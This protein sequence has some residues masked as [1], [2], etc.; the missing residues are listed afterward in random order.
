MPL[1]LEPFTDDHLTQAGELLAQRHARDRLTQPALPPRFEDPAVAR[2]AVEKTWRRPMTS[3]A[4][5]LE[6]GRLIG[7]LLGQAKADTLRERHV[8]V[9]LPGH[10]L[11]ADK[12]AELYGDLYAAAG[13]RWVA[14]GCFNHYALVP[15]RDQP[16]LAAWFAL[17]FGMEQVHALLDLARLD[18]PE[19]PEAANFV[20]R[21]ATLA[22]RLRLAE[23]HDVIASH[24]AGAPVWG[25][26]LPET[27]LEMRQGYGDLAD[28]ADVTAWLALDPD[29][30]R[31]LG[32]H[33]YYPDEPSD[34]DLLSPEH[35]T[36]LHAA[37]TVAA[38]RRRGVGRALTRHGLL[39]AR[40]A[41]FHYVLTD[42][43]STNLLAARFWPR[44]GFEPV[45]IRLVR[46]VD[47]RILWATGKAK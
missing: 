23:M 28:E 4:V 30:Q 38:A 27:L 7:Y 46:R 40:E 22:D 13:E 19:V 37:G 35:T 18:L 17:S 42:W 25:A 12:S 39:A 34:E 32:L 11:A 41:G 33:G 20:I 2:V 45:A 15:A 6:G 21:Q 8:W 26:T 9:A 44:Q 3:G 1:Q 14:L 47:P 24:Q 31:P 29:G 36:G 16:A 10:A 43:R 5:A